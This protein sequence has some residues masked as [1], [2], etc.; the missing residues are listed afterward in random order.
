MNY[1]WGCALRRKVTTPRLWIGIALNLLPLAFFKYFPV[2]L[3]LGPAG[4][5]Q[6]DLGRQIIL[7]VGMSFW[8][9]Q[10]LSYL[11]D[12]Y[13][14]EELDPS[15]VEF[16]L[17]MAFWPTVLSGPICRLPSMLPQF[18]RVSPFRWDDLSQG[19]LRLLYGVVMKFVLAT[20]LAG[21]V[22]AGFDQMKAGWG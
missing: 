20:M 15:P 21:G 3:E 12:I 1:T 2:L 6:Y 22:A 4:S 7:P 11:F 19:S 10:G 5:W 8:T 13:F 17:Y 18:R 9:F 16:C 14:E